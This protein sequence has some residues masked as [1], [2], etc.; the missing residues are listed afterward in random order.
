M[1]PRRSPGC[2]DPDRRLHLAAPR[3]TRQPYEHL[4][5]NDFLL[6]NARLYKNSGRNRRDHSVRTSRTL[7][8]FL[9]SSLMATSACSTLE[10]AGGPPPA[11]NVDQDIQDLQEHYASVTSIKVYYTAGPESKARRDEFIIGRLTL[12]N[13]E[14]IKFVQQFYLSNA[15]INSVLDITNIG[16]GLAAT[17]VGPAVT[18][19]I[20]AAVATG[21]TGARLSIERN[22]FQEK[23]IQVLVTQMNAQR[24]AALV[25][26]QRVSRKASSN[27][28]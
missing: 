6:D 25:P 5:K 23:T 13:L 9:V 15:Q 10:N 17:L 26:I 4:H 2:R 12:Y 27:I 11:F 16:I 7:K 21:L 24:T 1:P 28:L 14:Y 19:S 20:L 8:A 3:K 22:F 18:K